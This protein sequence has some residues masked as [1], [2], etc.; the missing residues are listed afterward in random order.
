MVLTLPRASAASV[1]TSRGRRGG[2]LPDAGDVPQVRSASDPGLRV[3]D[4]A[5]FAGGL[6]DVGEAVSDVG[7][8]FQRVQDRREGLARDSDDTA[9]T[10]QLSELL[11]EFEAA[12]DFSD[13]AAV[14]AIGARATQ[15]QEKILSD[16]RGGGT[17]RAM[18]Q[19]RLERRRVGFADTVAVREIEG[20]NAR[21]LG[22][23]EKRNRAITAQILE[24][25]DVLLEPD[26]GAVF[27]KH[28]GILQDEIDFLNPSPAQRRGFLEIG[29]QNIVQSMITPLINEGDFERAKALL[30]DREIA[31]DLDPGIRREMAGRI[32]A[33]ER[34]LGQ[35]RRTGEAALETAKAVLGPGASPEEIRTAA[36]EIV[37]FGDTEGLQFF[38]AGGSVGVVGLDKNT[39]AIVSQIPGPSV[40]DQAELAGEI[41]KS[42][43]LAK[44]EVIQQLLQAA[45]AEALPGPE[46]TEEGE[47]GQVEGPAITNP[48]GAQEAASEDAQG[49]ARLF[50][51]SRRLAL[52]GETG[53][54]NNLLAQA[55]FIVENS[56]DI[57][58]QRELD[59]PLSGELASELGVAIGTTYRQVIGVLPPSPGELAE[60]RGAGSARGRERIQGEEQISFIDEART[61]VGDLLDEIETDPGVVGVRGSLRA[62]GQT[63]FGVL[64]DLGLDSL[65]NTAKDLAFENTELGL[66]SITEMFDSPTL[67]VLDIMENSIGL[68][69]A[70]L[71][72]PTGRIPVDVIRRS[73]DDVQLKGL[74]SST[75][76]ENRLN[77]VLNQLDRR[78]KAIERRF[79]LPG[80][81]TESSDLPQFKIE[82]GKL[83]PV[84]Q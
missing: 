74:K 65:A 78:A 61:M 3:P 79:K 23:F 25:P 19:N 59:K 56:T 62:T 50:T 7:A 83:V 52:I 12:G 66:D 57:Q 29:R 69:L 42:K 64:G 13:E 46:E 14:D 44:K 67:S 28:D 6:G 73:I 71:R 45:G 76:I 18:L 75:Q 4:F 34:E 43:L 20:S 16:H 21:L 81:E 72:T 30:T 60:E 27:R 48:F 53:M 40:E 8:A 77:F 24:D 63:A 22:S 80:E 49:V 38:N 55:R 35:A 1:G 82:G 15:L 10:E 2:K 51:A 26:L 5:R 32:G 47:A 11:R 39:G 36:A 9:Y 33:A 54:A 70:R 37:G 58:R 17:S 84:E 68:I 31:D 41:E